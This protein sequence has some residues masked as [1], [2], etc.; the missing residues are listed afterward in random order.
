[1]RHP[2]RLA[3]VVAVAVLLVLGVV[4]EASVFASKAHPP[5]ACEFLGGTWNALTGWSCNGVGQP[6][7]PA[8]APATTDDNPCDGPDASQIGDCVPGGGIG[9]TG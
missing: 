8:P 3:V 7:T 2:V 1:M 4:H 9:G 5:V 6:T